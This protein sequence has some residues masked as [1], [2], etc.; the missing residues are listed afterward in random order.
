L[1]RVLLG[2]YQQ[3]STIHQYYIET[4]QQ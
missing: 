3:N 1:A 4:F 2:K